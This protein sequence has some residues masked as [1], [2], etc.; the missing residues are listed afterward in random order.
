MSSRSAAD[1]VERGLELGVELARGRACSGS[2]PLPG[3]RRWSARISG[4]L[5]DQR[6]R[7]RRD[8][9]RR[10]GGASSAPTMSR[11]PCTT[12]RRYDRPVSTS[13][14]SARMAR[15]SSMGRCSRSVEVRRRRGCGRWSRPCEPWLPP[16]GRAPATGW[17][18]P[19]WSAPA[20]SAPSVRPCDAPSTRPARRRPRRPRPSPPAAATTTAAGGGTDG[21]PAA[22]TPSRSHATRLAR[23]STSERY[24]A[25]AGDDHLR[26]RRTTAR[27]H[28]TLWSRATRT[29]SSSRSR[30]RR[31]RRR[32]RSS[33]RPA[34][35]VFYCD[36]AGHR[37]AGMEATLT[38]E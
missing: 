36:V 31:D 18:Y 30:R 16:V 33:S 25:P 26:L 5:L 23:R 35:Y 21:R 3:A 32:A 7:D 38:V 1:L 9:R 19:C 37:A 10:G 4:Q 6:R 11:R 14:H 2:R 12:R 29:T 28:H 27:I 22:A 13:W 20:S 15:I 24:T 8:R 34:T 17:Y